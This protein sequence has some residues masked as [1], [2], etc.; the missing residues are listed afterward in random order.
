M[1][2]DVVRSDVC[3][4]CG[5]CDVSEWCVSGVLDVVSEWYEWCCE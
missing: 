5:E 1:V 3:E 2:C 4:W